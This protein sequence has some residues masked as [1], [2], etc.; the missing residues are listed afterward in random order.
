V[1]PP[2]SVSVFQYTH[3]AALHEIEQFAYQQQAAIS[4]PDVDSMDN[5]ASEQTLRIDQ[6]MV[7]LAFDLLSSFIVGGIDAVAFLFRV[8]D[9]LTVDDR[10]RGVNIPATL[11]PALHSEY[12]MHAAKGTIGGPE[13]QVMVGRAASWRALG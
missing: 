8:L 9:A 13:A 5:R 10:S 6:Q 2:H 3:K 12:M 4:V 7:L 1:S 11:I